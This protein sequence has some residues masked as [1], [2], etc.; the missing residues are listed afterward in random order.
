MKI[1]ACIKTAT[2]GAIDN[3]EA[4]NRAGRI[5]PGVLGQLD[6]RAVEMALKLRKQ[7]GG[8]VLVA[9]VAPVDTLG[10]VREALALGADRAALLDDPQLT[11]ADVLVMGRA[12]AALLSHLQANV[13]CHCPWPG[14]IDGTLLWAGVAQRLGMPMLAQA[15]SLALRDGE[16]H[17]SRQ[18]ELGDDHVAASSPC[19]VELTDGL[20][21]A[22]RSSLKERQAARNKQVALLRLS[23]LSQKVDLAVGSVM[24]AQS[25][26][27]ARAQPSIVDDPALAVGAI[28]DFIAEK[29]LL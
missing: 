1:V 4:F 26:A 11:G 14:D 15:R 27:P 16:I 9:A 6:G 10:A 23:D 13:V 7:T 8:E 25:P 18:V 22:R 21:Q 3:D 17:V 29:R 19:I 24:L 2:G 20:P 12:L 5:G 28:C